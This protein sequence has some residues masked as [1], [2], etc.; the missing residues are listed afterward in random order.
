MSP[1]ITTS[2]NGMPPRI[3]SGGVTTAA[4]STTLSPET[5][6]SAREVH[7]RG[8]E[9]YAKSRLLEIKE[10]TSNMN[11]MATL[12][13]IPSMRP[14]V[15]S[16]TQIAQSEQDGEENRADSNLDMVNHEDYLNEI[17]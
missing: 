7:H 10:E 16:V 8:F 5:K 3:E 9:Q 12:E 6:H 1:S 4:G 2:P 14:S 15:V 13:R 11:S 17:L